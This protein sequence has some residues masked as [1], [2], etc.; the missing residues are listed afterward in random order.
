MLYIIFITEFESETFDAC[1]LLK[2]LIARL[3]RHESKEKPNYLLE[4]KTLI[5]YLNLI[6]KLITYL[7]G[8]SPQSK[9][10]MF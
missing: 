5:G 7:A 2:E 6:Q 9:I 10:D 8:Y 4:D 1:E 3:K